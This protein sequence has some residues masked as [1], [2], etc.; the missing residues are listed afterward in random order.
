[1]ATGIDFLSIP[2]IVRIIGSLH[3]CIQTMRNAP[4][5]VFDLGFETSTY[6]TLLSTFSQQ[7]EYMMTTFDF[8]PEWDFEGIKRKL[9]E[10]GK[11]I[12]K[13]L[14]SILAEV[15]ILQKSER[16]S[17][18]KEWYARW[19]WRQRKSEAM[20]LQCNLNSSKQSLNLFV[21]MVQ[22]TLKMKDVVSATEADRRRLRREIDLLISLIK[23]LQSTLSLAIDQ[24]R[25]THQQLTHQNPRRSDPTRTLEDMTEST[26]QEFLDHMDTRIEQA[27]SQP[28]RRLPSDDESTSTSSP[29]TVGPQPS[30]PQHPPSMILED[31]SPLTTPRPTAD[32]HELHQSRDLRSIVPSPLDPGARRNG[33]AL[34]RIPT[35]GIP[36][37]PFTNDRNQG[38]ITSEQ[39][40]HQTELIRRKR[41]RRSISGMRIRMR[42]DEDVP[43]EEWGRLPS[44]TD[45]SAESDS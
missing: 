17:L 22:L 45:S 8:Q 6:G 37:P 38:A 13:D 3:R 21:S 10:Q 43:R 15:R 14:R 23:E 5:E 9:S 26:V 28:P 12:T 40:Q 29:T 7:W 35:G 39:R 19:R 16:A 30:G 36:A 27:F 20:I 11:S 34:G 31:S 33:R 25:H 41:E 1:M 44:P 42:T 4:K 32:A 2:E 24:N 18:L